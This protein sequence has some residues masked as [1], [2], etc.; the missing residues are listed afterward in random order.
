MAASKVVHKFVG[1]ALMEKLNEV[2]PN[3]PF[4]R[5]KVY[6]AS[7]QGLGVTKDILYRA[8]EL[9]AISQQPA[10]ESGKER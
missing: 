9:A 2:Y 6:E 3:A 8:I 7:M 5:Q 1:M 10:P 4:I